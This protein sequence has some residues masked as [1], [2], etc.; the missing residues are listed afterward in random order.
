MKIITPLLIAASLFMAGTALAQTDVNK[1]I[2][3]ARVYV[4]VVK[5]GY[6]TPTIYLKLANEYYFHSNYADAKLWYEKVFES[7]Q[8]TDKTI[9][10]RYKQS[11]KALKLNPE[12]NP[13]LA[14]SAAN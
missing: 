9:L 14:V 13:Y 5:E 3:V 8:P 7:E 12:E 4:Q 6:G 2:D 1:D 11:L 10:F